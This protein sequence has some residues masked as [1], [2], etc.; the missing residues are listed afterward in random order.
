MAEIPVGPGQ[1]ESTGFAKSKR[2]PEQVGVYRDP[3]SGKQLHVTNPAGADALVRAG[4][5]LVTPGQALPKDYR[6]N[7]KPYPKVDEQGLPAT[8][9][10]GN[11]IMLNPDGTEITTTTK[12]EDKTTK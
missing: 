2:E 6:L 3:E 5:Q 7:T 10:N 11:V 4:W 9:D 8:D 12:T 1:A